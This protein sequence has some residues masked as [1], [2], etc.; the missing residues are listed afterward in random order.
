MRYYIFTGMYISI[1]L[2]QSS[3]T[4]TILKENVGAGQENDNCVSLKTSKD[5]HV[6][7]EAMQVRS[8]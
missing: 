8:S 5:T 3:V 4:V 6:A 2:Y 7:L 1:S